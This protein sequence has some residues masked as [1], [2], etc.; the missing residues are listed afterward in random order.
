[1]LFSVRLEI[2]EGCLLLPLQ[3]NS[4]LEGK[5]GER[6]RKEGRDGRMKEKENGK[7]GNEGD[8]EIGRE[9]KDR[10]ERK[11]RERKVGGREKGKKGIIKLNWKG[12]SK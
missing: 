1:M 2:K 7:Q 5:K 6:K 12:R 11:G 4:I 10:K 8:R 3:V 9:K